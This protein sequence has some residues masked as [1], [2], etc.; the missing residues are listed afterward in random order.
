MKNIVICSDGTNNKLAGDLTNVARLSQIAVN[1]AR[2]AT[3]YDPGVGT[4]ASPKEKTW[5]GKRWSLLSG[6]AFGTGL[7]ENVFDAYRFL[8]RTYEPGDKVFLFGFSRGAF[9]ARVVAGLLHGVGLLDKDKE[10]ML[11]EVWSHYREIRLLPPSAPESERQNA[12]KHAEETAALRQHCNRPCRVAFLGPWDTVGSVG[13]YNMNQSFPFTFENSSVDVVRHA[14]SLDERRAGFRSNVFK[15]DATILTNW[16]R[17]GRPRVMNVWFPGVHSDIGGGYLFADSG[18]AMLAFEWMVTE[19]KEAGLLVD[20]AKFAALLK[21]CPPEAKAKIHESLTGAWKAMEYL[22]AR[23]FDWATMKTI[24]RYQPNKP[25]TMLQ[26]PFLHRSVIT[27]LNAGLDYYPPSL[28]PED[29]NGGLPI[30]D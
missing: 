22:P 9:T 2:Q 29:L 24:W 8:M 15:A 11:P 5:L 25:R 21:E 19:A 20:D 6:L 18:L 12:A 30:E 4:M 7:D 16:K 26:S 3:F 27:R 1:D 13:M 10:K 28:K 14:V 23:R 17:N